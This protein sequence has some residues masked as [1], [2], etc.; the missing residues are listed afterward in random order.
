MSIKMNRPG[1]FSMRCTGVLALVAIA[2][3]ATCFGRGPRADKKDRSDQAPQTAAASPSMPAT[4]T[5][6][7]AID[8]TI[9]SLG[10]NRSQ[11]AEKTLEQI[12]MGQIDFG[13]HGKQAAQDALLQLAFHPSPQSE[14]FLLRILSEAD[15]TIR[16][17]DHGVYP[18]A[19][20]RADTAH[21]LAKTATPSLRLQ[22]AKAYIQSGTSAAVR[23]K[24]EEI[25]KAPIAANF[26]AQLELFRSSETS[27]ALKEQLQK[28]LLN[29]NESAM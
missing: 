18:A 11:A 5:K 6:A 24:I 28:A 25:V 4:L 13:G 29:K 26:A 21:V 10:M 1:S 9:Q 12:V 8:A 27:D 20:L 2:F 22:L 3:G 19:D 23:S 15:E 16:P 14:A 17:G 7:M